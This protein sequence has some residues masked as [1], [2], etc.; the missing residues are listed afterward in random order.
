MVDSTVTGL[1]QTGPWLVRRGVSQ[2]GFSNDE[3]PR[4][5]TFIATDGQ[6]TWLLGYVSTATLRELAAMLRNATIQGIIPVQDALNLDGGSSSGLW[7]RQGERAVRYFEEETTVRNFI[8]I[9]RR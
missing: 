3:T 9:R 7:I 5:R 4:R 6:G 2:G 8:G 1:L